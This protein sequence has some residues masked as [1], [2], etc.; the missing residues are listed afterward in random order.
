MEEGAYLQHQVEEAE[1]E[2]VE[3]HQQACLAGEAAAEVVE[4]LREVAQALEEAEEEV[5]E[6]E[7]READRA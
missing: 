3:V 6:G 4:E 7:H 5:A 2:E 1:A